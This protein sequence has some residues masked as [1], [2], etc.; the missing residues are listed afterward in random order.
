MFW[1]DEGGV[2]RRQKE[3]RRARK[4]RASHGTARHP[5]S[6]HGSINY[7]KSHGTNGTGQPQIWLKA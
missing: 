5:G 7:A 1:L 3:E 4:H 2:K 6:I